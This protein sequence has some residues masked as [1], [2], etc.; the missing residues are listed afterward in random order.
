MLHLPKL[1]SLV[2][3]GGNVQDQLDAIPNNYTTGVAINYGAT[4]DLVTGRNGLGDITT[5]LIGD[6]AVNGDFPFYNGTNLSWQSGLVQATSFLKYLS[7]T[8][9]TR[10]YARSFGGGG[11]S[12]DTTSLSSRIDLKANIASPTFT[13]T[14]SGITGAMVGLGNVDNT[15]DAT[16]NSAVAVLTNKDLTAVTN[17][18]RQWGSLDG[19]TGNGFTKFTGATTSE[20][21]YTLPDASSKILT[22]NTAVTTLEGGTG[23]TS[24][25]TGDIPYAS[26][27]NVL[28]RR[29]IGADGQYFTISSG[30]PIWADLPI[31][32]PDQTGEAG[33]V[34]GTNG[35]VADWKVVPDSTRTL[36]DS[37]LREY[38]TDGSYHDIAFSPGG[39]GDALTSSSLA[40]FAL[41][42]S[43]E[44]RTLT[45][46]ETGSGGAL[47]F[48]TSPTFSTDIHTPKVIGSTSG[49]GT[50]QLYAT[51]GT[52]TAGANIKFMMG[53]NGATQAALM[54]YDGKWGIGVTTP[55]AFLHLPA[56]T[57]TAN[58]GSLKFEPGGTLPTIADG[59]VNIVNG[60]MFIDSLTTRDTAATRRWV[61]G[62]NISTAEQTLSD[63]GIT[64]TGTTAP[65]GTATH[66]YRWSKDANRLVT[67][68]IMLHYSVAGSAVTTAN[69]TLPTD[70]RFT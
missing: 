63:A 42:T 31:V 9:A 48:A 24:Y 10:A 26:A 21:T 67:C 33:N 68:R 30:V 55:T 69:I 29:S 22:N 14:V 5:S 36:N 16:K 32:L 38:R 2:N 23:L 56:P 66:T 53:V 43:A 50:L 35:S 61:E 57:S 45:S 20:K 59:Q 6:S 41:T 28:A 15:S 70:M 8:V 49:S 4:T 34:L 3:I 12:T 52:G 17:T 13:G 25:T 19:G 27:P 64:W 51:S 62:R 7:D 44:M 37:T 1:E 11:G 47:V 40:Q 39:T 58:T 54:T 65:S 46:D 18:F 60:L